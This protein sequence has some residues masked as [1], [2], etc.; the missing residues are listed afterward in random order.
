MTRRNIDIRK[1]RTTIPY[2]VSE[3][4]SMLDITKATVR[5]WIG[6]GLSCI[7]DQKPT[8]VHGAELKLW[9]EMKKQNRKFKCASNE[10]FCFKCRQPR[11][12]MPGSVV[13]V[14]TNRKM[15]M[16]KAICIQCGIRMNK[17][18]SHET[19]LEWGKP[20]QRNKPAKLNLIV[21]TDC[22]LNDDSETTTERDLFGRAESSPSIRSQK[23]DEQLKAMRLK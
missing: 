8:L 4:A 6:L 1:I 16:I 9:L 10:M 19:A 13:V 20:S 5:R 11:P 14:Q 12:A 17:S 18:A 3:I 21:S 7:D 15:S 22:P 2:S 23:D